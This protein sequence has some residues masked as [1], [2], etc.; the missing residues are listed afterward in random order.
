ML[1]S[2]HRPAPALAP[3][4]DSAHF[5]RPYA[6]SDDYYHQHQPHMH[7]SYPSSSAS[8]SSHSTMTAGTPSS[9]R[10]EHRSQTLLAS[11]LETRL[12]G[13][14]LVR[15]CCVLGVPQIGGVCVTSSTSQLPVS[16]TAPIA[17]VALSAPGRE[18]SA[19]GGDKESKRMKTELT[20]WIVDYAPPFKSMKGKVMFVESIPRALT[21]IVL[22]HLLVEKATSPPAPSPDKGFFNTVLSE[23][24]TPSSPSK[25][26]ASGSPKKAVRDSKRRATHSQIERRRREKINDR[27]V[28]LRSIVP[29]CAQELE[30]RRR[31]KQEED[32]EA[33]RIAAGGAPKTYIDAATGKPKRK[34]NRKKPDTKKTGA[35]GGEEELGLHKL[36]VLTHAINYIFEL[37]AEIEELRTGVRP[38]HVMTA[39]NPW[40]VKN[41]DGTYRVDAKVEDEPG[42][43]IAISKSGEDDEEEEDELDEDAA[44]D[45]EE[46]E[47]EE[48]EDEPLQRRAKKHMP[49]ST[50]T[51]SQATVKTEPFVAP[52]RRTETTYSPSSSRGSAEVSPAFSLIQQSPSTISPAT[53]ITSPMMSLSAESPILLPDPAVPVS[54]RAGFTSL[55]SSALPLPP[56]RRESSSFL[57]KHLSLSS[58]N[59]PA[60]ANA[61]A[62]STTL[63]FPTY[64]EESELRETSSSKTP[65]LSDRDA[66]P[67]DTAAAAELLLNFSTSPEVLRPIGRPLAG[68]PS[69]SG[70]RSNLSSPQFRVE[71]KQQVGAVEEEEELLDLASPPHFA[72]DSSPTEEEAE[73]RMSDKTIEEAMAPVLVAGVKAEA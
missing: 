50:Y 51:S 62:R 8:S 4:P 11:H 23:P 35:G 27:L 17:F 13:N 60:T 52:F 36:E 2:V 6:A 54:K 9:D 32:D 48:D 46:G 40:G 69:R 58:P 12:A 25:A 26:D 16:G 42:C 47:D 53:T 45:G 33:A 15:D 34:R 5:D 31:Q 61:R 43:G 3:H 70:S 39:D 65:G 41:R 30:D 55:P 72:L 71:P 29:A 10:F 64:G 66:D 68:L 49:S 44:D 1:Y 24:T 20:K 19:Q 22:R 56:N 7:A 37:K 21:G 59:F 14:L 18:R 63:S 38:Q 73:D 57:F 67:T 28:T